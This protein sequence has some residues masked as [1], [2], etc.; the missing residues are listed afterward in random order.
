MSSDEEKNSKKR[1]AEDNTGVKKKKKRKR[2]HLEDPD[3][4][5]E[6]G[7]NRAFERM[8]SQLLADH[9]AR[10]T[11]RFGTDLSTVELSDLHI[12][13]NA[14]KGTTSWGKPRTME[15]LPEF[16]ESFVNDPKQLSEAPK[17]N[18]APHTIVVTGAGIRAADLVRSLR[19][20]QK[21]GTLVAKLFAK[22]IKLEEAVAF[23]NKTRTGIAVGTP[24]R[25]MQ[26]L[27]NGAL[28]VEHLKR[29]IVDASH[30]DVKK[31]G[32]MDS[33]DT[34]I[35]LAT[36]LTRKEFRERYTDPDNPLD[37]IFY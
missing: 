5:A 21:K 8:D 7:V 27:D 12:S 15:N 18:G 24:A 10:K 11:T 23:L 17:E 29:I 6:A 37:L 3:L 25:L 13:A 19:K 1:P 28:S 33:K 36:W 16:L 31:R 2:V 26:L 22:H 30:I 32:V 4:D 35:P 14:I 20:F 34:M 9:L